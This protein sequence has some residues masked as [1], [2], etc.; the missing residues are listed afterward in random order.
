[1]EGRGSGLQNKCCFQALQKV[2]EVLEAA[3]CVK[4]HRLIVSK[5]LPRYAEEGKPARAANLSEK[6]EDALKAVLWH[7]SCAVLMLKPITHVML[8]KAA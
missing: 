2:L 4:L 6:E 3:L 8:F 1:M 7:S 5:L